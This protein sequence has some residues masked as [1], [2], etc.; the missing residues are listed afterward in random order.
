MSSNSGVVIPALILFVL[1]V[2]A[3]AQQP[4]KTPRIGVLPIVQLPAG[5]PLIEAF[6][7]GLRDLGYV[8]GKNLAFEYRWTGGKMERMPDLAA[9]LVRLK[10]DV[11]VVGSGFSARAAKTATE[12]IPIVMAAVPDPVG[13]GLVASLARPGGNVTGMSLLSTELAPKQLELLKAAVPRVSRVAVLWDSAIPAHTLLLKDLEVAAPTLGVTLQV[14]EVRGPD[15]LE[16]AFAAMTR[17]RAGALL[18]LLNLRWYTDR[19]RFHDLAARHRLPAMYSLVGHADAGGL[20]A[21]GADIRDSWRRAAT[22]VDKV[23]KGAKPGALP[24]EQPTKFELVLNLKAAKALGLTIPP[25]LLLR[26]DRV[27]E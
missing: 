14:L 1:A 23:L 4:A 2:A 21:Y 7:H 11:I 13:E 27:I 12:T 20:M 16:G 18:V 25:S 22:Y 19:A 26:A 8:A 6:E 10:V 17:E 15:E 9:E 24:I 5:A 3:D